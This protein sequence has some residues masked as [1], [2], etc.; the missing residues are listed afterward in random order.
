MAPFNQR[1][2]RS[3]KSRKPVTLG[4]YFIS[5]GENLGYLRGKFPYSGKF[6]FLSITI[7]LKAIQCQIK[8]QAA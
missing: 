1:V 3:G 8:R 2:Q 7:F 5:P 4:E 6:Y